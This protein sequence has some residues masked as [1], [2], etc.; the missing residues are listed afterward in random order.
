MGMDFFAFLRC[1]DWEKMTAGVESLEHESP[2]AI[3]KVRDLWIRSGGVLVPLDEPKWLTFDLDLRPVPRPPL[4]NLDIGLATREE[5]HLLFGYDA[6]LVYYGL[7]WRTFLTEPEWQ[8]TMLDAVRAFAA[9]LGATEAVITCDFCPAFHG[10]RD[11]MS[12]DEALEQVHGSHVDVADL[13]EL[14]DLE[15]HPGTWEYHGYWHLPL[16]PAK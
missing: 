3:R 7:R 5:F 11:G 1:A 8:E 14:R 12:F 2:A 13:S 15:P 9:L 4:P 16:S 10:F 6:V